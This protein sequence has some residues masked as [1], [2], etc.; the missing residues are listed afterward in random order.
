MRKRFCFLSVDVEPDYGNRDTFSGVE[1]L[2]EFLK[3]F[4]KYNLAATL[5]VTGDVLEK[6]P[7]KIKAWAEKYEIAC[8]SF[9]HRFWN[10]LSW[11]ERKD[12]LEKFTALY[13]DIFHNFPVGFR[14]PSDVIDAEALKLLEEFNF[15]YDSSVVPC[16]PFLKRYRGYLGRAPRLPY[17]P[18]SEN[19]RL[20]GEME[21]LEIPVAGLMLGVP[22]A[23]SWIRKLPLFFYKMLFA[24]HAPEFITLRFHPWDNLYPNFLAKTEKIVQLLKSKN[25]QFLNGQKV[26]I[27]HESIFE[28]RK[29]R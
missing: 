17:H 3:L 18:S 12:E 19:H 15:L 2:D 10:A 16:Y 22:L 14:A 4:E 20:P 21:I 8:H 25:Y 23:G 24:L 29:S 11:Q 9:T 6:Y 13:Q 27:I 26:L 5:F 1:K 28:N 7:E